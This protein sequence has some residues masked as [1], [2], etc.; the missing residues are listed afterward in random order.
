MCFAHDWHQE[1]VDLACAQSCAKHINYCR[2]EQQQG[3]R[4]EYAIRNCRLPGLGG[5][6][7]AQFVA[8]SAALSLA[9]FKE[10]QEQQH[11]RNVVGANYFDQYRYAPT[12]PCD[13]QPSSLAHVQIAQQRSRSKCSEE[14]V[15]PGRHGCRI[16]RVTP[17]HGQQ[18]DQA[19]PDRGRK[20][21]RNIING[22]NPSEKE[23][24]SADSQRHQAY[25]ERAKRQC[26]DQA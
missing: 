15:V 9:L 24:E 18:R 21:L 2:Y 1:M 4:T 5:F 3:T 14:E 17:D 6:G 11:S 25:S 12:E 23:K 26:M 7:I 16:V 19:R 8:L 10:R 22:G 13:K 20:T